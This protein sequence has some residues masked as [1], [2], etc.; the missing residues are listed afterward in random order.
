MAQ[1]LLVIIVHFLLHLGVKAG[2]AFG[3][4]DNQSLLVVCNLFDFVSTMYKNLIN[5]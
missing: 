4:Y 1:S 2:S 5:D 3:C